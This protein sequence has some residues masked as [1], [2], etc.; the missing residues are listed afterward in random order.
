MSLMKE[1]KTQNGTRALYHRISALEKNHN[2]VEVTVSSYADKS[3]RER[4]KEIL[5]LTSRRADLITELSILTAKQEHERTEEEKQR[6]AKIEESMEK[7]DVSG[8]YEQFNATYSFAV[9]SQETLSF[10]TLYKKLKT[11]VEI[12]ADSKDC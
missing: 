11:E 1:I 5:D 12:F 4:E 8:G 10:E 9:E 3:Y 2:N 6:I 7:M